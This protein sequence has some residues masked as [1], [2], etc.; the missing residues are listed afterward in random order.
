LYLQ[1]NKMVWTVAE[2][3]MSHSEIRYQQ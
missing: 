2:R 1:N 3:I